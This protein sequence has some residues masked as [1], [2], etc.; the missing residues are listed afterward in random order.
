MMHTYHVTV[1]TVDY[2]GYP[3][4]DTEYTV[5]ASGAAEAKKRCRPNWPANRFPRWTIKAE[6]VKESR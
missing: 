5:E 6:R 3:V 2:Y 4:Y 1:T